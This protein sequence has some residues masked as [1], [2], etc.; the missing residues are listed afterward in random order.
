MKTKSA[1]KTVCIVGC[2]LGLIQ[3]THAQVGNNFNDLLLNISL[4]DARLEHDQ[5]IP[6]KGVILRRFLKETDSAKCAT[7]FV[8]SALKGLGQVEAL[9]ASISDVKIEIL[10]ISQG[11]IFNN[12]Q[13]T[14]KTLYYFS[15]SI[16]LSDGKKDIILGGVEVAG[17]PFNESANCELIYNTRNGVTAG[18]MSIFDMSRGG[19]ILLIQA[20]TVSRLY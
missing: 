14:Y 10:D 20:P 5:K 13:M 16:L 8:T 18:V 9:N 6:S 7:R 3:V 2:L 17:S 11:V 19:A 12:Q 4:S 1:F 15:G